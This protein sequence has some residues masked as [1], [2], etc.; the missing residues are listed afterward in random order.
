MIEH[1]LAI[2]SVELFFHLL[3]IFILFFFFFL[4]GSEYLAM[5]SRLYECPLRVLRWCVISV[6]EKE[7]CRLMKNA[8]ARKNIN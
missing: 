6:Y 1:R 2:I 5:L 4:S 7:K 3:H 8:F